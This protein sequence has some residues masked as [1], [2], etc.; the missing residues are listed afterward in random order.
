MKIQSLAAAVALAAVSTSAS[1]FVT[2]NDGDSF[3]PAGLQQAASGLGPNQGFVLG[4]DAAIGAPLPALADPAVAIFGE[5]PEEQFFTRSTTGFNIPTGFTVIDEVQHEILFPE[6]GELEEIGIVTDQ[7]WRNTGNNTLVFATR[8]TL[9]PEL[10]EDEF[11]E[12]GLT[13]NPAFNTFE[14]EGEFNE[15]RR[16]YGSFS[17]AAGFFVQSTIDRTLDEVSKS[18]GVVTFVNDMSGEE[19]NPYSVWH[20]VQTDATN[21]ALQEGAL[22]L[23][24]EEDPSEGRDQDFFFGLEESSFVPV[25]VPAALPLLASALG[26]LGF[27]SRR[28]G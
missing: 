20:L 17:T 1:A 21:Y 19:D 18:G 27:V 2:I 10:D 28:R 15:I 14:Y 24:S 7:V 6:D 3:G 8:V 12:D 11:L 23:F 13:P 16:D 5:S 22:I 4:G 9:L 25:P 26:A